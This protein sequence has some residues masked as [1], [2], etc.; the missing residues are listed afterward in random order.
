MPNG[1]PETRDYFAEMYV[2][3]VMADAGWNIYFPRRDIG[4]DFMAT[5]QCE[6]EVLIRPV[7]VKGKY[8]TENVGDKTT[9]GYRGRLSQT[10][11]EMIL[12]IPYFAYGIKESPV[13]TAYIPSS[14]IRENSNN[15]G[16]FRCEPAALTSGVPRARRD[17]AKFF[18]SS[19]VELA[20]YTGFSKY[21][22]G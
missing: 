18:D 14:L 1:A 20:S 8:P 17:Y 15:P 2:A 21:S 5:I 11:P 9:Y 16:I 3:G 12:A 22:V 4:F 13:T 10:H 7:Q 19:G 6:E